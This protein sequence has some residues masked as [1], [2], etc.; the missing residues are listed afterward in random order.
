LVAAE[1]LHL[2][3]IKPFISPHC[4]DY[5]ATCVLHEMLSK[6]VRD[7]TGKEVPFIQRN[8]TGPVRQ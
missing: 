8:T 7:V 5:W 3:I 6:A 2:S 4:D 1:A